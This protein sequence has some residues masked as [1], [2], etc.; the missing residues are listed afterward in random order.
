MT[1]TNNE[2]KSMVCA[3]HSV[4]CVVKLK[5]D[6]FDIFLFTLTQ[7]MKCNQVLYDQTV[8]ETKRKINTTCG[9]SIK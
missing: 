3:V 7:T 9:K 6:M 1:K 8:P 4:F 2:T 5:E